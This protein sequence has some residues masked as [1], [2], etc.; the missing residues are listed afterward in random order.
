MKERHI[1]LEE[2]E[3]LDVI[4]RLLFHHSHDVFLLLRDH[5][6][7]PWFAVFAHICLSGKAKK[8]Q[9]GYSED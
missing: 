9:W 1:R 8:Q 4:W 5:R 7:A 3:N 2:S 6:N